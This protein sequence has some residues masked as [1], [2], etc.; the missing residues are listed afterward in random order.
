MPSHGSNPPPAENADSVKSVSRTNSSSWTCD[1]Q[2]DVAVLL[3]TS[4]AIASI[5]KPSAAPNKYT[6]APP[7]S[8]D[9]ALGP[10]KF[11]KF[12]TLPRMWAFPSMQL[13]LAK[14]T[15]SL[16]D[17]EDGAAAQQS[18][19]YSEVF[20]CTYSK[21]SVSKN[22][23]VTH[24][25]THGSS[26]KQFH[27]SLCDKSYVVFNTMKTDVANHHSS[28]ISLGQMLTLIGQPQDT[29][30]DVC[31]SCG[32]KFFEHTH[33]W[34][35]A[36]K[37]IKAVVRQRDAAIESKS[38]SDMQDGRIIYQ[39]HP[40]GRHIGSHQR[41]EDLST[42]AKFKSGTCRMRHMFMQEYQ[43]SFSHFL[44]IFCFG[45]GI[46]CLSCNQPLCNHELEFY[47]GQVCVSIKAYKCFPPSPRLLLLIIF[48]CFY[49]IPLC[50]SSAF[51]DVFAALQEPRQLPPK[52]FAA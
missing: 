29:G 17:D 19:Q 34:T 10:G 43:M 41:P 32:R 38:F 30:N 45:Q 8:G 31:H 47:F 40:S 24:E 9:K 15:E 39:M 33:M 11:K 51:E 50:Q 4:P 22:M 16:I 6:S 2:L 7:P 26:K 37:R 5:I 21:V 18:W 25:K 46:L 36:D 3:S 13:P 42:Y 1:K 49:F 48:C 14:K 23:E 52:P 12:E 20:T 44:R 35:H 27:Y 28:D